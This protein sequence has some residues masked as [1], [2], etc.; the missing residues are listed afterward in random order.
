MP[1]SV[2]RPLESVLMSGYIGQGQVVEEFERGLKKHI[3]NAV[4]VN[5][6]TSA[7]QMALE[8]LNVRGR[9]VV[10]T[11]ATCTATNMAILNAGGLS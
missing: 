3:G 5:S 9:Y 4:T 7:L 6:C 8:I 2:L 11:P 10:P 1:N